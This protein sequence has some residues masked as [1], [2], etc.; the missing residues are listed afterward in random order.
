VDYRGVLEL[1]RAVA[2][3]EEKTFGLKFDPETEIVITSGAGEALSAILVTLLEPEEELVVASPFF[4]SYTDTAIVANVKM[5]EVPVRM[6][7]GWT[8]DVDEFLAAITDKTKMILINSPN[9]PAGYILPESDLKRIAEVA[10]EKDLIVISDECYDEFVYDGK[11]VSIADIP[12][13]RERTLIVKSASKSYSMTGWRLGYVIGPANAIKYIAKTHQYYSTCSTSFAQ[14]GAIPAY[15]YGRDYIDNMV[16]EFKRRRDFIYEKM[17]KIERMKVLKPKGAFYLLPEIK[18][19]NMSESALCEYLIN[20]AGI[21]AVPGSTYGKYGAG[22]IRFTYCISMADLE[23]AM[24][25][26]KI[27]VDKL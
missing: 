19:L 21:V 25:K 13:M 1:R 14:Y 24:E 16:A 11:H 18:A 8:L 2:E 27:A 4:A 22:H 7:N 20:E 6:E 10:I 3:K 17:S 15:L 12:G 26:L 5:V 23:E 9:N